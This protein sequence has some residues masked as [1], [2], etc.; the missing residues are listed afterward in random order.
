MK[1]KQPRH[2]KFAT[3][4]AAG[5]FGIIGINQTISGAKTNRLF[6]GL[7]VTP[8]AWLDYDAAFPAAGSVALDGSGESLEI[9]LHKFA[10]VA[11]LV[12]DRWFRLM[13]HQAR[14]KKPTSCR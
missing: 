9:R 6:R 1:V 11:E 2:R 13:V 8:L 4:T 5:N 14:H 12:A 3:K 7:V 10:V